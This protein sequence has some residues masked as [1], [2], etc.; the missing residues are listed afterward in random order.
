MLLL[1]SVS[2]TTAGSLQCQIC[3]EELYFEGTSA[4]MGTRF[5]VKGYATTE[6]A[7]EH[8]VTKAFARI[9]ELDSR[10][11]D[12]DSG[13]EVMR[14][15][16]D[17]SLAYTS[18]VAVSDDLSHVLKYASQL[19]RTTN[20]AVDVTIGPL[21]RL[22]RRAR[23]RQQLPT[24]E[25]IA[26]AK[27]RVNFAHVQLVLSP[28]NATGSSTTVWLQHAAMRF[29]LGALAKGYAADEALALMRRHGIHRCLVDAGGDLAIGDPPP[30]ASGWVVRVS[31]GG[32]N[33]GE[34]HCLCLANC[35][36]ATSGDVARGVQIG[37]QHYSHI[38]D[39]RTGFGLTHRMAATVIAPD[40]MRADGMASAASL[41]GADEGLKFIESNGKAE[42]IFAIRVDGA[43]RAFQTSGFARF[44]NCQLSGK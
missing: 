34:L 36:I 28:T 3:A 8:S 29:D 26:A 21:S 9:A 31:P 1:L 17:D 38:I 33:G 24:E 20:G 4:H 15:T 27:A 5:V 13:S 43:H 32:A 44:P 25:Q 11:S 10:L 39:P 6:S 7:F 22:W 23:R 30:A 41:L 12:Y 37:Q 19:H 14:L 40:A 18:P 42:A 2:L 16:A 35:G